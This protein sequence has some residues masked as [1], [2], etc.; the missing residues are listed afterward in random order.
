[1]SSITY[2]QECEFQAWGYKIRKWLILWE[3]GRELWSK[4]YYIGCI[5]LTFLHFVF[6][7]VSSNCLPWPM[8]SCTGYKIRVSRLGGSGVKRMILWKSCEELRLNRGWLGIARPA[9]L[10][11][12]CCHKLSMSKPWWWW[13]WWWYCSIIIIIVIEEEDSSGEERGLSCGQWVTEI[14]KSGGEKY[15][16]PFLRNTG[17]HT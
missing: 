11:P 7:Y 8:Q 17:D 14:L 13:W 4:L 5:C 15:R 1:M 10:Q 12:P 2:T 9:L 16:W 3:S 6:S